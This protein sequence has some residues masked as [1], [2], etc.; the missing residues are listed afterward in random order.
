MNLSELTK[1]SVSRNKIMDIRILRKSGARN[2]IQL[3]IGMIL[4]Y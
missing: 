1:L 4:K 3:Q 2:L